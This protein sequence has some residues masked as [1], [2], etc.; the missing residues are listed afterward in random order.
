[1]AIMLEAPPVALPT[2][3]EREEDHY[4]C[5]TV[6]GID[7]EMT[8]MS[9]ESRGI[10]SDLCFKLSM[11]GMAQKTGKAYTEIKI[12]LSEEPKLNRIPDVIFVPF[13]LWPANARLPE[14]DAWKIVPDLCVEIISPNDLFLTYDDKIDEYFAAG[15]K[16]VWIVN[17][18]TS[19]MH[20]YESPSRRRTLRRDETLSG[21]DFLP[22]FELPLSELFLESA[23]ETK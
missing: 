11:F 7:V 19:R 17:P 8:P 4:D 14:V 15:V 16:Q 13:S 21:I 23:P 1:M 12:S 5:E 22:G 6:N 2:S 18:R 9:A 10:A 20:V 3:N